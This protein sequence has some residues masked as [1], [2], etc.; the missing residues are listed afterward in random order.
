VATPGGNFK[1]SK[2]KT[3]MMIAGGVVGVGLLGGIAAVVLGGGDDSGSSS[4]E[5]TGSNPGVLDPKPVSNP[6]TGESTPP[7]SPEPAPDN[8]PPPTTPESAPPAPDPAPPPPPAPSG[9]GVTLSNG[10]TIALPSGWEVQGQGDTS[11][12]VT[13]QKGSYV[14]ALT[15]TADPAQDA[16]TLLQ[17]NLDVVLPPDTYSDLGF[18]EPTAEKPFGSITSFV[19]THY[20]GMWVDSQSSTPF[21]GILLSMIRA[22]GTALIL[23]AEHA[24]RDEFN[25]AI[26]AGLGDVVDNTINPFGSS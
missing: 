12:L 23:A 17:D 26:Q 4:V 9:D 11:A 1:S 19:T 22:D 13:D 21:H 15:G 7:E 3:I 6:G 16:L 8:S 18:G 14:F 20:E 5:A 25:D 10:V 24:P 2:N